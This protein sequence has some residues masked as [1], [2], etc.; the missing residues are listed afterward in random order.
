MKT[1]KGITLIALIITIIVMLILVGVSVSVA[2]NT[3]L[4][5]TAQ[6]AAKNTEAE[7]VNEKELSTGWITVI[8][9]TTGKSEQVHIDSFS[10]K[11]ILDL[12]GEIGTQVA[13]TAGGV[14]DWRILSKDAETGAVTIVGQM[15]VDDEDW[16]SIT[17]SEEFLNHLKSKSM[18]ATYSDSIGNIQIITLSDLIDT[19]RCS[20]LSRN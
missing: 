19:S 2:L 10:G 1:Q 9:S 7:R 6:G 18:N 4:F 14:N 5:K 12:R 11:S 15:Q 13:Y 17:S 3:G 8:N 16:S 20:Y